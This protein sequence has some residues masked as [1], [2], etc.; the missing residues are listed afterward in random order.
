M[1]RNVDVIKDVDGNSIVMIND[2]RFEGK[3]SVNWDDVKMYLKNYVGEVY[4]IMDT[5]DRI[6][7]GSDLPNE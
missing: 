2:I 3:R 1:D 6:Y 4:Q 7:I 5:K